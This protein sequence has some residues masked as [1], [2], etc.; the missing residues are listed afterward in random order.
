MK[1]FP[2]LTAREWAWIL[3][4]LLAAAALAVKIAVSHP[5]HVPG[6][7]AEVARPVQK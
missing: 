4:I 5:A 7:T 2:K 6:K 1:R 3:A